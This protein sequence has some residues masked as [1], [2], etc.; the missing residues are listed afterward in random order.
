[1]AYDLQ[2][3]PQ[4]VETAISVTSPTTGAPP[5]SRDNAHDDSFGHGED[6]E[7][8][9]VGQINRQGAAS[10]ITPADAPWTALDHDESEDHAS[11]PAIDVPLAN[12]YKNQEYLSEKAPYFESTY[13]EGSPLEHFLRNRR[14][15]ITFHPEVKTD[16]GDLH[17]LANPLPKLEINPKWRSRSPLP[18]ASRPAHASPLSRTSGEQGPT[19]FDAL[20]KDSPQSLPEKGNPL[21]RRRVSGN[22]SPFPLLQSSVERLPSPKEHPE[23]EGGASLTSESTV[24]YGISEAQTP[25]DHT[26][27]CVVSPIST[28]APFHHPVSL[29]ESSAWPKPRRQTSNGGAQSYSIDRKLSMR[30]N[31]SRRSTSAS[32]KSPASAFLARFAL[33]ESEELPPEP[34]SE[35]QEVGEYVLGRQI[36]FG[37]FS[38]VREAYTIEGDERVLRAVKI[39]RRQILNK[40]DAENDQFQAEFEHEVRL[41]RCLGHRHILPLIA[42]YNTPFATFCFTK[43]NTGG[44]LFDLIRRNRKG[45]SSDLAR[46]YAYQL[47]SAIRYLHEDMRIVHRDIKLENCL[48]DL[49]TPNAEEEGGNLLLCDFG[50]AEFISRTPARRASPSPSADS[51][52]YGTP[53]TALHDNHDPHLTQRHHI[54][55][56]QFSTSV[57]GSLQYA[58]PELIASP[59][60]LLSTSVDIWAFGVVIYALLVGDLPFQHTFQ[61]KVQMMI[62]AGEWDL[63]ALR[64]AKGASEQGREDEVED[65]VAG[66]LCMNSEERWTVGEVL[67]CGWLEGC[68]EVVEEEGRGWKL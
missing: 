46:R 42:V 26:M 6:K 34:D 56:S 54:A 29:E 59:A 16:T 4:T 17:T 39:V 18:E 40:D 62:Q 14:P 37:G 7:T 50:L 60:G 30:S 61:P 25:T 43:L 28:F 36:G 49:S 55:S 15:S 31:R 23:F 58:A 68:Q 2:A 12:G 47:A 63:Q 53:P 44:T 52:P 3:Q 33:K 65:V 22:R 27:D 5:S 66:C 20:S 24:S 1:M 57:A 64:T 45:L 11:T 10:Q 51:S 32:Q 67:G 21:L 13:T 8:D 48:L 19:S 9:N 35:G 38:L 41:W